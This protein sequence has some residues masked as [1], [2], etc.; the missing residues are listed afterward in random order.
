LGE[1]FRSPKEKLTQLLTRVSPPPYTSIH[2]AIG[3]A[4]SG[5]DR[6]IPLF[7]RWR[8]VS[9]A[10]RLAV[11]DREYSDTEAVKQLEKVGLCRELEK[12]SGGDVCGDKTSELAEGLVGLVQ[13]VNDGR[14]P[15]T[16]ELIETLSQTVIIL[17][18]RLMDQHA[19]ILEKLLEQTRRVGKIE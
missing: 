13:Q 11:I 10:V 18:A 7:D 6:S 12:V 16:E 2:L 8:L 5:L 14:I 17:M 3:Y 1:V 4:D 19:K 9:T 15:V